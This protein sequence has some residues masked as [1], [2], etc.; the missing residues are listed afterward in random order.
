M[1]N[2]RK[3]N[4]DHVSLSDEPG[5]EL[6]MPDPVNTSS[7]HTSKEANT[8]KGASAS[9]SM[10]VR[11]QDNQRLRKQVPTQKN[12][13]SK[14]KGTLVS[15]LRNSR[16]SGRADNRRKHR[17]NFMKGMV[18]V[19]F[20]V[21][22]FTMIRAFKPSLFEVGAAQVDVTLEDVDSKIDSGSKLPLNWELPVPYP[23]QLR[24]PMHLVL[25]KTTAPNQKQVVIIKDEKELPKIIISGIVYTE[26]KPSI[27]VGNMI[28]YK[29][30]EIMGVKI[31]NINRNSVELEQ[32]DKKWTQQVRH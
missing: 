3:E 24:D 5:N 11:D 16:A 22:M 7:G 6:S 30:D 9:S 8:L 10:S 29:G 4:T 20:L 1:N 32:G 15:T 26:D 21:F 14:K 19:I 2:E 28:L 31:L 12:G 23:Q 13:T 17:K 18:G 25:K 27:L